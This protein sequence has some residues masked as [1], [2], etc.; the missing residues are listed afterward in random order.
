M[1]FLFQKGHPQAPAGLRAAVQPRIQFRH[2][3]DETQGLHLRQALRQVALAERQPLSSII[4]QGWCR[5]ADHVLQQYH[6]AARTMFCKQVT[7]T[8]ERT[9][10]FAALLLDDRSVRI[11]R[12]VE[13][14]DALAGKPCDE[15]VEVVDLGTGNEVLLCKNGDKLD[16][17]A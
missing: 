13:R 17:S 11:P 15:Q 14:G 2:A 1:V 6:A 10:C 12:V 7:D 16:L 4:I 3:A 5:E 9:A 8:S